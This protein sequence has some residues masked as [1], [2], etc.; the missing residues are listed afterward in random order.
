[1]A[2]YVFGANDMNQIALPEDMMFVSEPTRLKFFDDKEVKKIA[3]GKIHGLALCQ[4]NTLYSWGVNDDGAL[5]RGGREE[6]PLPIKFNKPIADICAGA[7]FSA[8]L[9]TDGQ[10]YA[11]GTFKSSSGIIGLAPPPQRGIQKTFIRLSNLRGISKIYSGINH[12]MMIDRTGSLWTVGANESCQ[13]GWTTRKRMPKRCLE[14]FKI[15]LRKRKDPSTEYIGGGCGGYHSIAI[16]TQNKAV[17]WGSN[18]NGQLGNGHNMPTPQRTEVP[19]ADVQSVACGDTFTLFLTKSNEVHGCGDNGY[20]QVAQP[21]A[22]IVDTPKFIIKDVTRIAAGRDFSIA[23]VNNRLFGWGLNMAGELATK[24]D[25][26]KVP[27]EIDFDF[28]EIVDFRCGSEFV[29]VLTK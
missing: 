22:K 13:L 2:V 20:S 14:P 29:I 16:T 17:G 6:E 15:T 21:D 19:L 4:D 1:M 10:V 5:G 3:C 25:E 7:S 28:G 26:V 12:L 8:I 18:F 24:D 9:T 23:Q 27:R 11:C